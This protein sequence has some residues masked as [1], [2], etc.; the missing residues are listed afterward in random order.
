MSLPSS[1]SKKRKALRVICWLLCGI[2]F[3]TIL[4]SFGLYFLAMFT[5]AVEPMLALTSAAIGALVFGIILC[6]V[7]FIGALK[8]SD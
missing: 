1:P 5:P 2:G 8:F 3:L 6:I 7:S 4:S